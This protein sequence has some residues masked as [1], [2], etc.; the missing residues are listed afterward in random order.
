MVVSLCASFWRHLL[1]FLLPSFPVSLF[2]RSLSTSGPFLLIIVFLFLS[3]FFLWAEVLVEYE[4]EAL[5]DDELTLRPGDVI[6]NVRH[7]EEDGWME[8]DLNGKRGLFPDNFVKVQLQWKYNYCHS[9]T[10]SRVKNKLK[11]NDKTSVLFFPLLVI[12][13]IRLYQGYY[14]T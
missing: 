3:P 12:T 2:S 10:E 9:L 6:K 13:I 8:G 4:Y 1:P 14:W 5:H 7:I 11:S